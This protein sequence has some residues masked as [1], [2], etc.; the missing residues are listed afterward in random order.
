MKN[1]STQLNPR[2]LS[3][4]ALIIKLQEWQN[5]DIK[6]VD[7]DTLLDIR[8]VKIDTKKPVGERILQVLEQDKNPCCLK[9]G[10]MIVKVSH[11]DSGVSLT[12]TMLRLLKGI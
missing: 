2:H 1:H 10:D 9:H 8:T 6:T 4:E 7:K 12:E 11:R 5:V 3:R